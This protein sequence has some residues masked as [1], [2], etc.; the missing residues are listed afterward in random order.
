MHCTVCART[1]VY[2][3]R[4]DI[5]KVLL[6]K[7]DLGRKVEQSASSSIPNNTSDEVRALAQGWRSEMRRTDLHALRQKVE[8]QDIAGASSR[9]EVLQ[10]RDAI[11]QKRASLAQRGKDLDITERS[12]LPRRQTLMDKLSQ[13][14]KRGT[15][16]FDSIHN[17]SA[18]TR[19]FL[20]REAASLLGLR[21]KKVRD[22]TGNIHERFLVAGHIIPDLRFIHSTNQEPVKALHLANFL[23][24]LPVPRLPRFWPPSLI[25][26][27]SYRSTWEFDLPQKSRFLIGIIP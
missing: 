6:E 15:K 19:A 3:I 24:T 17:S 14:A 25:L 22:K 4:L 26:S 20:C 2:P 8:A 9:S 16:S 18:D 10:L 11:E 23:Q 27:S 13:I 5:A 21:Q 1:A 7:E 12:L